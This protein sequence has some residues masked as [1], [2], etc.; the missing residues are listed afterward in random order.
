MAPGRACTASVTDYVR[1]GAALPPCT[2]HHI[3]PDGRPRVTYPAEY[4]GWFLDQE[5]EGALDYGTAP[6]EI[7]TPR[8]GFVYLGSSGGTIPGDGT[9]PCEVRGGR[10]PML[11]VTYDGVPFTVTRP[12]RFDLPAAPGLHTVTVENGEEA[13]TVEF[14]V[15]GVTYTNEQWQ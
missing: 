4:Q 9:V 2:Y 7:L 1:R 5:R 14:T 6:L 11:T 10:A 13:E 8:Q 12:F 15:G 3:G